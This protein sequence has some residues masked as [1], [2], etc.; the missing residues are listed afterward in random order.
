[1][2]YKPIAPED[3]TEQLEFNCSVHY[4]YYVDLNSVRSLLRIKLVNT[5]GS[6]IENTALN[7]VGCVNNL[8][9]AMFSSISVSLNG[10]QVTLH[11]SI[12]HYKAYMEK[13]NYGSDATSIHLDSNFR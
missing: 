5:D 10:K 3:N 1:M 13:V 7:T 6:D 9:H 11:G 12:Y 2:T 8:L 4:D